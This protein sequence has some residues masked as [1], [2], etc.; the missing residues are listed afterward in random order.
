MRRHLKEDNTDLKAG[1]RRVS[2]VFICLLFFNSSFSQTPVNGFCKINSF[3]VFHGYNH[4]LISDLN[5][6]TSDDLILYSP[7][8]KS[9]VLIEGNDEG[10]FLDYKIVNTPFTFSYLQKYFDYTSGSEQY[11][12]TSRKLRTAGVFNFSSFGRFNLFA[13]H[14]FD[15]FPENIEIGDVENNGDKEFLISGSGFDGISLLSFSN[16]SLTSEKIFENSIYSEAIFIDLSNDGYLDISAHNIF[17][18]TVDFFYNDKSGKFAKVRSIPVAPDF[19]ELQAYDVNE[20]SFT[21]LICTK[22]KS[23]KIIF[24]DF[25]SRYDSSLT[26]PTVFKPDRLIISD[27]NADKKPDIAYIDTTANILSICFGKSSNSFY[28]ELQYAKRNGL[29]DLKTFETGNGK[30]LVLI[31]NK[32][33]IYT[34]T[35][36]CTPVEDV[37]IIPAIEPSAL[38]KFDFG[39]NKINDFCFIDKFTNTLNLLIN[40]KN[41]EPEKY[42]SIPVSDNHK[43]IIV[44]DK[45]A[46]K[47]GFYCYSPDEKLIEVIT[48]DFNK[49]KIETHQIYTNGNIEDLNINHKKDVVEIYVLFKKKNGFYLGE[50]EFH[51]FRFNYRAYPRIDENVITG[52]LLAG[53]TPIVN[54]W[55]EDNDRLKFISAVVDT[56]S[57]SDSVKGFVEKPEISYSIRMINDIN[58]KTIISFINSGMNYFTVVSNDSMFN[59]SNK[60]TNNFKL[61]GENKIVAGRNFKLINTFAVFY[62][63]VDKSFFKVSFINDGKNIKEKKL[64]DAVNVSDFIIS[65][66]GDGDNYFVF[67]NEKEGY[68]RLKHLR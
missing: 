6:D 38:A 1:L 3:P 56:D 36:I 37:N 46:F 2:I 18:N 33:K 14:K 9:L 21:D 60:V 42:Y 57:I 22:G 24:G 68:I 13:K 49:D 59:I 44:D 39:N 31:S 27:L 48:F 34:I 28:P 17:D 50:Y 63:S 30:G 52:S 41:N 32:G 45:H 51:D 23:I 58:S 47:K 15:S 43:K 61:T 66:I 16:Y 53:K 5:F 4:I 29:K 8:Q 11:V 26:V 20:D 40:D 67:T 55:K 65:D 19:T 64:F 54:Y 35:N 7:A 10:S 12:F 62:S 25:N